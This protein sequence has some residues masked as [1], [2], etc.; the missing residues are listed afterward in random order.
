MTHLSEPVILGQFSYRGN[1]RTPLPGSHRT[2]ADVPF[3]DAMFK[4]GRQS[5]HFSIFN[6]A[7]MESAGIACPPPTAILVMNKQRNFQAS[8]IVKAVIIL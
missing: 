7:L 8:Q 6:V 4:Y 2:D 1:K 5:Y 3:Y